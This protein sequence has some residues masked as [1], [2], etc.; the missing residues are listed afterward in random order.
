MLH[1]KVFYYKFYSVPDSKALAPK[2]KIAYAGCP[3]IFYPFLFYSLSLFLSLY[4]LPASSLQN[5][6]EPEDVTSHIPFLWLSLYTC[7]ETCIYIPTLHEKFY[8]SRS[9][10]KLSG[11]LRSHILETDVNK[12]KELNP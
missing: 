12:K 3:H 4:V 6:I 2:E 7:L 8:C 9:P 10:L 1:L 11:F 5:E